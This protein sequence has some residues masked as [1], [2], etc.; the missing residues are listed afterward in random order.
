VLARLRSFIRIAAVVLLGGALVTWWNLAHRP[1]AE[2]QAVEA[3]VRRFVQ[4]FNDLDRD[5][6]SAAFADD[7]TVIL[8]FPE[9]PAPLSGRAAF[10]PV[11]RGYFERMRR[12]RTGPPYLHMAPQ[13][14]AVQ[15][16]GPGAAVV[17]FRFDAATG[18]NRRSIVF[19]RRGDL[20]LIVHMHGSTAAHAAPAAPPAPAPPAAPAN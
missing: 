11:F 18:L 1:P 12:E 16:L 3:A 13:G 20:W 14:L 5:R 19:E 6:F 15:P 17:T 10:E 7:A 4:A 2:E 8:P 9:T